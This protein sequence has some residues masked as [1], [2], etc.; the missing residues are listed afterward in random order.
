MDMCEFRQAGQENRIVTGLSA[1]QC[2]GYKPR[3]PKQTQNKMRPER[4]NS[5]SQPTSLSTTRLTGIPNY[6]TPYFYTDRV[7]DFTYTPYR[8]FIRFSLPCQ[9][10][11]SGLWR[12]LLDRG[13]LNVYEIGHG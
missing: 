9:D 10:L 13:N 11:Y 3:L 8:K 1:S 6:S 5:S 2:P 12:Y 4:Q 7:T